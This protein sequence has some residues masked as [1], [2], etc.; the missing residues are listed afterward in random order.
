MFKQKRFT[1]DVHTLVIFAMLI[2]MEI[3]LS[4]FLAL[5]THITKIGFN[6]VPIV[7][8]A[9]L[10][11][12][13]G[14]AIVGSFGDYLGATLFPIGQYFPGFTLTA[15][16]TGAIFGL[17]LQNASTSRWFT[18]RAAI[19]VGIN[20]L[21]LS[22]FLNTYWLYFLYLG[23]DKAAPYWNILVPRIVQC[24]ILIPVQLAVILAIVPAL[25]YF[26]Q[27]LRIA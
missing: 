11:G 3:V 4:R 21:I 18:I 27:Q 25:R 2:A 1:L 7:I 16:L 26:K 8:A 24:A 23:T 20:N 10:Y 17:F 9:M 22:L 6:F 15:L 12:P 19:S 13:V 5:N 14:G